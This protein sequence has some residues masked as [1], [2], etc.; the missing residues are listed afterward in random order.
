MLALALCS[1][2]S[3][4]IPTP[5]RWVTIVQKDGR[6]LTLQKMGDESFHYHLASTGLPVM[7]NA[8]G[9]WVYAQLTPSPYVNTALLQASTILAH[10][11]AQQDYAEKQYVQSLLQSPMTQTVAQTARQ[12]TA[13]R[14]EHRLHQHEATPQIGQVTSKLTGKKKGLVILV[15]FQDTKMQAAHT[16]GLFDA[17][18]N[19]EGFQENQ[20]IGSVRDYFLDQSYGQLDVSFDVVGPI[21][22][23][24]S[25]AHYG[26]NDASGSDVRAGALVAEACNLVKDKVDFSHYDWDG[27]GEVE[28]VCLI[29]AGYSEA[30]DHD[31]SHSEWIWP[32]EWQLSANDYGSPLRLDGVTINT[33]AVSS[34]LDGNSGNDL[35]GIGTMCHEFSHCLGLPDFYDT[36]GASNAAFGMNAWSLMDYGAYNNHGATPSAYTAYERMFCGWLVPTELNSPSDVQGLR[37]VTT[38]PEAYIIYNEANRQEYYLLANHQQEKWDAHAAAR[39]LM[40]MH[41]DYDKEAWLQNRVNTNKNRQRCTIIPAD[42]SKSSYSLAGDLYPNGGR[43]TALSNLS[44]PAARLNTP[45]SDGQRLMSKDLSNIRDENGL[46]SFQFMGGG[47]VLHINSLATE[48]LSGKTNIYDLQGKAH[49]H[50]NTRGIYIVNGQKI[51]TR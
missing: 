41:V 47:N 33:Y 43:N 28:Q 30:Q 34:E 14:H 45:N 35:A 24:H 40:V 48:L 32:H 26:A 9:D 11:A 27:D 18:M 50:T 19:Q 1:L 15:N 49:R 29:Y 2:S 46:I 13:Q 37:P 44:T 3:L 38:V 20:H 16:Q 23:S 36:S 17:M 4:A 12:K 7:K 51:G 5:K 31:N 39:G 6:T 21:T 42:N 25:L 10:D 8:A 22:V